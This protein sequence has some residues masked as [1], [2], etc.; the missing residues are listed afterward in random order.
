[1]KKCLAVLM[2]VILF[3]QTAWAMLAETRT[4][5][6]SASNGSVNAARADRTGA[7]VTTEG[8]GKYQEAVLQGNVYIGSDLAGTAVTTVAGLSLNNPALTLYNPVGSGKN[9]VLLEDGIVVTA[10]PA[11]ATAFFL[12]YNINTSTVPITTTLANVV[13]AYLTGIIATPAGQC[14]RAA[15][16]PGNP[17]A[18]RYLGMITGAS[19]LTPAVLMDNVDG[20][21]IIPPGGMI[22]VQTSAAASVLA[23]F[24]WEEVP[25]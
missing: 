16:L 22:S 12:A 23:H 21:V 17:I 20:K 7:L 2:S 10:A 8:H 4:G 5:P 15:Q 13:N 24:E 19:A 6:A 1:M 11:A 3:S 9:L 25:L 18:F 14:Y